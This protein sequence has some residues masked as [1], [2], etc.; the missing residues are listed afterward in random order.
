MIGRLNVQP[1]ELPLALDGIPGAECPRNTVG[2]SHDGIVEEQI[3]LRG[4]LSRQVAAADE[5]VQPGLRTD[6]QR[7]V[8]GAKGSPRV[9]APP[10]KKLL[11]LLNQPYA[12]R[13]GRSPLQLRENL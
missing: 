8:P 13:I 6:A 2:Q 4:A 3:H 1:V 10:L 7:L 9:L 11:R 5:A 12:A